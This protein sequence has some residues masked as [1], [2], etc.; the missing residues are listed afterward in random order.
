MGAGEEVAG[1]TRMASGLRGIGLG[2]GRSIRARTW[3]VARKGR[4]KMGMAGMRIVNLG[5]GSFVLSSKCGQCP[6]SPRP[7]SGHYLAIC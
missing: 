6:C 1:S 7:L 4:R 3:V 5:L 2:F